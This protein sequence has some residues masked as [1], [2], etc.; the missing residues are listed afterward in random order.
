[1][2]EAPLNHPD[3]ETLLALSLGQLTE[4]ELAD[5]SA[6]LGDCLVCCNR[7]DQLAT[8][9]CLLARLQ[10]DAASRKKELVT[11]AQR[12]LA[13]RA[14]RRSNE[15]SS[16][17]RTPD[18]EAVRVILPAPLQVGDYDIL[19]EVGRGGMG[20]VYKC[21]H[22]GLRR[23][24]ALKM[25]LAGEFASPTQELRFRLEAELAAR[26]QHPN[27][28]QVYEIGSYEGRPFLVLEWIEGGSLANRLDGQPWPPS[29]AAA[30]IETLARAIDVAHG[31]GVVHRDLKPGNVLLAPLRNPKS[32]TRK[33]K[34]DGGAPGSDFRFR[35]SDFLPKI[36]D[37]GLAKMLES[38]RGQTESRM[39]LGTP[40]YAAPEQMDGNSK[41][42]GPPAD[43]YALGVILYEVLT[44]RP[45]FKGFTVLETVQQVIHQEP[46]PPRLLNQAIPRDLEVICLKCLEKK[47]AQRYPSAAGLAED[48]R[49]WQNHEPIR[50][51]PP[52]LFGRAVRWCRRHPGVT[53]VVV[54]MALGLAGVFWQW[55]VAESQRQAAVTASELAEERRVM[56][57]EAKREAEKF[58]IDAVAA[59][60]EAEEEA[61]G[62]REVA[63]FLGGLFEEAN[64]F[65]LSE[66]T[67]GEQPNTNPTA[68]EIV[69]RGA[70]RLADPNVLKDKPLVR[71]TLL[72]KVGHVLL[73]WGHVAKA[74]LVQ[75]RGVQ[76]SC[77]AAAPAARAGSGTS[78]G[79]GR[80]DRTGPGRSIQPR[81]GNGRRPAAGP[82]PGGEPR[83]RY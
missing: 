66:R 48:L 25:V 63:N 78:A 50:A 19:V 21:W 79:S 45:P 1:M 9:D 22:R 59:R 39:L 36:T 35:I 61:A 6:H 67:F 71:A 76:T 42:V 16:A 3:D 72:D 31:E 83:Y 57:E 75:K 58:G 12:R 29:E 18:P 24:A 80:A 43:V 70:K 62:A 54:V 46:V 5:V 15:A 20:V 77:D 82:A 37:F 73:I 32:E 65:V 30:L 4:A 38:D 34:E 28:V 26:V 47:P 51:R 17:T 14:L 27:I 64:P 7:I 68:M 10:Q 60:K 52:S 55:R 74:D 56:A 40:S 33:P 41:A 49:R 23:L 53:A 69:E 81:D 2:T 13:V 11:P 8:D 44:G